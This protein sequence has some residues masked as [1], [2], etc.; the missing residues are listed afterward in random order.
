MA[1]S[2][3]YPARCIGC[4]D[5]VDSD[6]GLCASCWRDTPFIG[7]TVCDSCGIPL[8]GLTE[9][10]ETVQCDSCLVERPLWRR[11]RAALLYRDKARDLVLGL[12]HSDREDIVRPAGLWLR[13]AARGL[14]PDPKTL[15]VP[16]PLHW[17]RRVKRRYNQSALLAQAFA[18][19]AGL[20]FGPDVLRRPRYTP[21]LE[22]KTRAARQ[23]IL[24]GAIQIAPKQRL[25]IAQR[26]V[27][28]VD[29]VMTTGATLN[30]AA[31]CCI[32]AGARHVDVLVLA[33]VGKDA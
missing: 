9:P 22:G 3:V 20:E 17:L 1:L 18:A 15:V 19:H 5:L 25:R 26:D 10:G 28:I 24:H 2:S 8:P 33:R 11:G 31:Q 13:H 21:S 4:G 32:S 30:A 14:S 6:F 12:K 7:G 16:V 29:D 23:D 27:L